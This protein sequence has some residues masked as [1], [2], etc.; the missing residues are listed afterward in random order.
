MKHAI[1]TAAN[2]EELTDGKSAR[3]VVDVWFEDLFDEPGG[4]VGSLVLASGPKEVV[5]DFYEDRI[6]WE[7]LKAQLG[8]KK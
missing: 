7:E 3:I 4:L 8:F 1:K 2:L 6:S 5:T